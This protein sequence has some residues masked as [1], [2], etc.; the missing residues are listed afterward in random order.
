M[1][2]KMEDWPLE[3]EDHVTLDE[4]LVIES[5]L[6]RSIALVVP[7]GQHGVVKSINSKGE[8]VRVMFGEQL[9]QFYNP[10]HFLTLYRRSQHSKR[11]D[12]HDRRRPK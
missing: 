5:S 1:P 11:R 6:N 8:N 9:F 7:A 3:V 2:M 10:F 12:E 4:D